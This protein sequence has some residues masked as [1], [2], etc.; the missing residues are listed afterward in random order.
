M[1]TKQKLAAMSSALSRLQ[2]IVQKLQVRETSALWGGHL[3]EKNK[4]QIKILASKRGRTKGE[5]IH[6]F[7]SL[8]YDRIKASSKASSSHSAI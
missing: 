1:R 3:L 5:R 6:S 8:S 4:L 7:S 2:D